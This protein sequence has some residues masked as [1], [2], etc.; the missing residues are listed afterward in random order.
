[1]VGD[2]VNR[3][4][5]NGTYNQ[6]LYPAYTPIFSPDGSLILFLKPVGPGVNDVFVSNNDG[7]MVRNVTN[8]TIV[9][10]RCPAWR[11]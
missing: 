11:N 4:F 7:T 5:L 6:I 1:V 8:V 3:A 10:K 9:D 2:T